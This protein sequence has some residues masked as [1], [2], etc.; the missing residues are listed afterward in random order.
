MFVN[1]N[2]NDNNNNDSNNNNN[3]YINK[4]NSN[5]NNS[6][7]DDIMNTPLHEEQLADS[8]ST[9]DISNISQS[10]VTNGPY[11]VSYTHLD[12]YKRQIL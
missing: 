3:D 2:S 1:E 7:H 8:L 9:F 10:S 12:V 6:D 5:K 4:N 11:T